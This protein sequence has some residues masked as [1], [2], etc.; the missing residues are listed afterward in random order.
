MIYLLFIM[1]LFCDHQLLPQ[2][3]KPLNEI[4]R[5]FVLNYVFLRSLLFDYFVR[6]H[7]SAFTYHLYHIQTC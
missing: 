2:I 5:L 1:F 6:N 4:Q 3:K 7:S